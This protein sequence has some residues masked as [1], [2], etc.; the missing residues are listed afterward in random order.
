MEFTFLTTNHSETWIWFR[1]DDDF[2]TAMNMTALT[3]CITEVKVVAFILM[4]NHA[5]F[6]LEGNRA[7]A[8]RFITCFKSHYSTYLYHKYK[9]HDA[10]RRKRVDVREV[11][12]ENESME[13]VI[14]YTH[15]NCVAANICNNPYEY[16]WG[17]GSAF[18]REHK[19]SGRE[20]GSLSKRTVWGL[21]HSRVPVPEHWMLGDDGYI[22]PESFV[23]VDF[24]ENKV[25]R[26]AKRYNFFLFN[27]SKAKRRLEDSPTGLMSFTDQV[28]TVIL[29]DMCRSLFD[30]G[31]FSELSENQ[32]AET[33]VQMNRR[34]RSDPRQIARITGLSA[35]KVIEILDAF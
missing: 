10:L 20:I 27:S 31:A 22:L 23:D 16:R 1:S 11:T 18:F 4:S 7:D 19:S 30:V 21:V 24:V 3:S 8:L 17:S 6:V 34:F 26:T 33:V 15:M 25:F 28:M 29:R 13:R 2:K 5:H 12:L 14:A 9:M 32:Q 35:E